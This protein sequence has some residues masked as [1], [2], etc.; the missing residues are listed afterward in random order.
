MR[1]EIF[2]LRLFIHVAE[3]SSLTKGADL[4]ALSV[5][6]ASMRLKRLE[7]SV[8]T[9]LFRRTPHGVELTTGGQVMLEHARRIS[10]QLD[11]MMFDLREHAGEAQIHIRLF[12]TTVAMATT[13]PAEVGRFI[14]ENP[15]VIVDVVERRSTEVMAAVLEGRADIGVLNANNVAPGVEQYEFAHER[16][17]LAVPKGHRFAQRSSILFNET[18]DEQHIN[19]PMGSS[20]GSALPEIAAAAGLKRVAGTRVSGFESLCRLVEMGIGV[21]AV[22]QAT[23]NRLRELM[24]VDFVPLDDDFAKIAV[25]IVARQ[26]V[27]LPR[28]ARELFDRLRTKGGGA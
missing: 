17:L 13:L 5:P 11:T 24:N 26:D 9:T 7:A 1:I 8:G 6:A 28:I 21:G 20:V 15:R 4:A 3:H 12:A 22:P 10:R 18:F 16:L 25:K 19:M 14:N 23:A 2:D 27:P